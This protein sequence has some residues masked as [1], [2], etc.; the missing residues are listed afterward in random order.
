LKDEY[1]YYDC[2]VFVSV[3]GDEGGVSRCVLVA[4]GVGVYVYSY[5][6]GVL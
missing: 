2:T 1:V 5:D 4:M 3:D 6:I